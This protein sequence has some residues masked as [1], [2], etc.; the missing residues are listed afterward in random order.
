VEAVAAGPA[1]AHRKWDLRLADLSALINA[2]GIPITDIHAQP[3][4]GTG[5]GADP[6]HIGRAALVCQRVM[7][8]DPPTGVAAIASMQIDLGHA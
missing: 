7:A 3:A 2:N 5:V 4:S 1:I 6:I 8:T